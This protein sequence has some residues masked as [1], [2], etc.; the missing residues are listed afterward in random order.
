MLDRDRILRVTGDGLH[1]FRHYIKG[2]WTL[3]K[4]FR[5]P[6]YDDSNPSCNIYLEKK[7]RVYKMKDF[8][9]D[10]YSGDC[11]YIVGKAKGLNSSMPQD[12]IEILKSINRDMCLGLDGESNLTRT[13]TPKRQPLKSTAIQA[14]AQEERNIT[15]ATPSAKEYNYDVKPFSKAELDLWQSYGI[16]AE[17]LSRYKVKS[18]SKFQ[19]ISGQGRN[20]T[21]NAQ[22]NE[23]IFGYVSK[24]FIKIYRP[25]SSMRFAYAGIMPE[26]YCFGLDQLSAKGDILFLVGG[27]KDV[28]SLSAK[29]FNAICFNSETSHIPPNIIS[30]LTYRFKHIVMLYDMDKT[31]L[32]S[33]L[34]HQQNLS[35]YGVM[36]MLLPLQG[37]K[38]EKDISDFFRLG[39][40]ADNLR[41]LFAELLSSRYSNTVSILNSCK[42]SL[43][44]PPPES[45]V[46][47]S[48]N[49]VP[50]GTNGNLLCVTGGEG[51]GKS[52]FIGAIIAG[53]IGSENPD[54]DTLGVTVKGNS[55][56]LPILLYD[57][58]QSESQVFK[59]SE[60]I[61][62]RAKCN[63]VPKEF[64]PYSFTSLSRSVRLQSII[65]SMDL[66]YHQCGG[67]HLVLIDGIA[68]LISGANNENES[69]A[70]VEELYR[71]AAIY[72]TCIICV[73]HFIPNGLKLRGHLGSELQRKAAAILSIERDGD[74]SSTSLIKTL[75][76]RDGSPLDVPIIKFSWSKE[77]KMH[78]YVGEKQKS[79]RKKIELKKGAI[80][81]FKRKPFLTTKELNE[82]VQG[83]FD[84]KDRAARNYI[85]CMREEGIVIE[86]PSNPAYLIIGINQH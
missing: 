12:F 40:S 84:I 86:D 70:I 17:T 16:T 20:Y 34:K 32:D 59:N 23:P 77:K 64:Q 68:D 21:F 9:N 85:A 42:V 35:K 45:E 53:A 82:E 72:N 57:T 15:V 11:F 46:I 76:V 56:K 66:F 1:I 5:N 25:L 75:K 22:N 58:E 14:T 63:S 10:D 27:E 36:R 38:E 78:C 19:S 79:E 52:N 62:R 4:C 55:N 18:I 41:G 30:K 61:M 37:V 47:V 26:Y 39:N 43:E 13:Y 60:N 54:M 6:L 33:S 8:G 48:I 44:L 51:T 81:I 50:L 67:I 24:G 28:M 3:G 7:S 2:D 71:L 49:D 69:I 29:G 73:L 80:D 74:N 31:G 65:E 83:Y